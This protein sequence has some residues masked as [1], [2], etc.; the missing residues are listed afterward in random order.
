MFKRIISFVIIISFLAPAYQVFA[1]N[2]NS[3][4]FNEKIIEG[5]IQFQ[6]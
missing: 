4:S 2:D 1:F 3:I 5:S 6:A